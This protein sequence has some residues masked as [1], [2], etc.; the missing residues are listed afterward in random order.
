MLEIAHKYAAQIQIAFKPHPILQD[1]L[2]LEWGKEKTEAYYKQWDEMPNGQYVSGDYTDIF[3]TS[4]AIMH[5]S[6]SFILEYLVTK[7]PAMYL[8]NGEPLE[9]DLNEIAVRAINECYCVGHNKA[10]IETFI[11]SVIEGKD[12]KKKIKEQFVNEN[13]L[14]PN[15]KTASQNIYEDLCHEFFG[16]N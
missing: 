3:L 16:S 9:R 1:R 11:K 5:D 4:D 15:G 7:K 12:I 8:H 10:D 13:L 14:P 6:G 2:N